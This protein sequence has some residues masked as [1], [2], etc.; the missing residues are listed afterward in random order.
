MSR[1]MAAYKVFIDDNF[2]YQDESERVARG[3]F[4]TAA[5]A[6][7]ACK[8]IVDDFLADAFKAGMSATDLYGQYA[9]FGDDPFIV[10]VDP[11]DA[12]VTFSAWHYA[13]V[14]CE[15]IAKSL[16]GREDA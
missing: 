16:H 2:H 12:P 5:E 15:V 1:A 14:R 10:P 13:R 7:A 9:S 11:K 4:E 8:A 6:V 3:T